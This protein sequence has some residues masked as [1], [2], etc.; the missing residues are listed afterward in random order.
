VGLGLLMDSGQFL[1]SSRGDFVQRT[2]LYP[3][4]PL[5][6]LDILSASLAVGIDLN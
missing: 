1:D 3:E 4:R 2:H 6:L 5:E